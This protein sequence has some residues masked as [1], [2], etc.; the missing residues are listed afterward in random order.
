MAALL[1]NPPQ[2]RIRGGLGE[3]SENLELD[4]LLVE[5]GQAVTEVLYLTPRR[6]ASAEGHKKCVC[7][8]LCFFEPLR[9]FVWVTG[10]R[11]GS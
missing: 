9:Y 6:R 1:Q 11:V 2:I 4:P 10:T 7:I 8:T 5:I 3:V